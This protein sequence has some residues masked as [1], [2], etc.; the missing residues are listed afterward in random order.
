MKP[1]RKNISPWLVSL[2]MV[3]LVWVAVAGVEAEVIAG[4]VV[5]SGQRPVEHARIEA[6]GMLDATFSD[7]EGRF[8]ITGIELPVTLIVGH[9]RFQVATLSVSEAT[10]DLV[11]VLAAKRAVYETIAVSANRG[12][13]NFAPVSIA[14][15]VIEPEEAAAPATSVGELLAETAAV[16]ENG[17]GGAF[18]TFSIR[19][20]SRQRVL[21]LVSGMR[22]VGER[23]AGVSA[24]FVDPLLLGSI[25]VVRGPSSTYYGSGALGGV[26]QLFPRHFEGLTVAAGYESQGEESFLLLAGGNE[27]TSW[28]LASRDAGNSEAPT[29][30]DLYSQFRLIS[31][32]LQR[33]WEREGLGVELSLLGSTASDIGKAN[34]DYPFR[35]TTYP[36]ESHL[37]VRL[38]VQKPGVWELEGALHPNNLET[39]VE[40]EG[41]S[42][43]E[44]ENDAFD[45]N[46]SW[47]RRIHGPRIGALRLGVDYFG[48][49]GVDALE[50]LIDVEDG[51]PWLAR[52]QKTLDNGEEDELGLFGA[53]EWNRGP[54]VVIAGGRL[55][56]LRQRNAN[57]E[58]SDDQAVTAFAGLVVPVGG[59]L[60]LA[61]NAG[62]GLRFPSLSERF[63]T[64][65][66][67]RGSV[68]G[69]RDL[70]PERSL[71]L[72]LGARFY[73]ERLFVA[74]YL[75]RN[76]IDDYIERVEIE[77]NRL[78]FVN[79]SSGRIE[80]V[81][82]ESLL[83]LSQDWSLTVGGHAIEG[84]DDDDLP[85]A[86]V[87]AERLYAGTRMNRGRWGWHL[88]WEKRL[89]KDD[90]GSGEKA[91]AAA[92]LV[93]GGVEL[94]VRP[95]MKVQA[96]LR[97]ALDEEYF[98]A[99][100][101]KVPLAPGRSV[102]VSLRWSRED[103]RKEP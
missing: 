14:T 64:G 39:R 3:M 86:D 4:K 67:G 28:G 91:I 92:D 83:Q 55:A 56:W 66:T 11:V 95:G 69:N 101:R 20:V 34:T 81:E 15:S 13:Q 90:P 99:A 9:P 82:V 8:E 46:L 21:T 26:V 63:F 48:R 84:R 50:R 22:I 94:E 88:R 97:N 33:R 5:S 44:L 36:K 30:D 42:T 37:V 73:G 47:Q 58:S 68:V 79:V 76:E 85:L 71:N 10:S 53:W 98:N 103:S 54:A 31:G 75:F 29:G 78:T 74:G 32:S 89:A 77:P 87:P 52:V 38:G 35:K 80:G 59:G 49:R 100:D 41:A 43:S 62:T 61:A 65:M 24:S 18:Q 93:S 1:H 51:L 12:E 17:Q 2:V 23:R 60:E 25:D 27:T 45:L 16:S 57:E 40:E 19:G 102:S 7:L 70:E 72:D 96:A 6:T